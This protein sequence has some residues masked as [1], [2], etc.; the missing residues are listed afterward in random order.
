VGGAEL[1]DRLPQV[2]ATL[3]EAVDDW[4]FPRRRRRSTA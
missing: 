4:K 1:A 3:R 2:G